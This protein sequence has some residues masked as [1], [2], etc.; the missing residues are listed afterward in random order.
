[1]N[2]ILAFCCVYFAFIGCSSLGGDKSEIENLVNEWS[3]VPSIVIG[4]ASELKEITKIKEINVGE[5]RESKFAKLGCKDCKE[6]EVT[7]VGINKNGEIENVVYQVRKLDGTWAITAWEIVG[8]K[9]GNF[10]PFIDLGVIEAR[11][12]LGISTAPDINNEFE[13]QINNDLLGMF[14]NKVEIKNLVIKN[15]E[16]TGTYEKNISFDCSLLFTDDLYKDNGALAFN[17]GLLVNKENNVFRYVKN[18]NYWKLIKTEFEGNT[19]YDN[20]DAQRMLE[21][22]KNSQLNGVSI[23]AG[24]PPTIKYK[25]RYIDALKWSD[26]N[27]VNY[28]VVSEIKQGEY[29]K[30]G[31]SDILLGCCFVENGSD[32]KKLWV[33]QEGSDIVSEMEYI[34]GSLKAVDIDNDGIYE[35]VFLYQKSGD[36]ASPIP[37]KLILHSGSNKYA[38][39]GEY[40]P[41]KE[42]CGSYNKMNLGSEFNNVSNQFKN[43]AVTEWN[44]TIEKITDGKKP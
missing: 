9:K 44:K 25:G 31:Y 11:K 13:N 8:K 36:G 40:C 23:S 30:N 32:I 27:G 33:I 41:D 39:R 38:I 3:K 37:L 28:L 5:I 43:F 20:A 34:K 2:K 15:I 21:K 6:A 35:N 22:Y 16:N 24:L 12:G 7:L 18:G 14:Y 4:G 1:M 19:S 29:G 17:K 26:K 42:V 10:Y